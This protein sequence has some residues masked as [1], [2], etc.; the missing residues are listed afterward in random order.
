MAGR[1]RRIVRR[2]FLA[3]NIIIAALFLL[4]CL[5]PYLHPGTWWFIAFLGLGF[6]ATLCTL[7]LFLVFT[8]VIKPRYAWLFAIS[9]LLGFK[10]IT[11]FFAFTSA[12][13]G[14]T[15][16]VPAKG[17]HALRIVHWNVARFKEQR[18]N[19]NEGSQARIKMLEQLRLQ[20]ADVLCFQE[21]IQN[22]GAEYYDNLNFIRKELGYPY[23]YFPRGAGFKNWYGQAIFSRYPLMDTGYLS[24]PSPGTPEKLVWGDIA[25]GQRIIRIYTGHLQSYKL[26]PEDYE[27][28]EKI[29]NPDDSLIDHSVSLF[30]K[31]KRATVIRANQAEL[32]RAELDRCSYPIVFT[33][34]LNDVPNSYAYHKVRGPLQDAFLERGFGVGRTYNALAPTL[35]IDYI[36]TTPD[37]KVLQFQR[38][39]RDLSDHYML[40]ADLEWKN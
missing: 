1:A 7:L 34:D 14:R 38:I 39:A 12:G 35:R 11:V 23:F 20:N 40:V 13:S 19:N 30:E 36:F 33:T 6:A 28:I 10:S 18:R 24:F 27:R 4:S 29:K 8:L 37:F 15:G 17:A 3:G 26:R 32:V 16:Y 21:F 25:L 2:I 9:L 5:A 22:S 31:L